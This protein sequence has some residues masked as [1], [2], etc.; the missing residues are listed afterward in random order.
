MRSSETMSKP[1]E[2]LWYEGDEELMVVTV[3]TWPGKGLRELRKG[4]VR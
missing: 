3:W 4:G 1:T 2:K